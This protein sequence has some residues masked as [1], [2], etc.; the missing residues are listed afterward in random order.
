MLSHVL[1]QFMRNNK[2]YYDTTQKVYT[3]YLV[4]YTFFKFSRILTMMNIVLYNLTCL[5]TW[6]NLEIILKNSLH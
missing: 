4:N 2:M 3:K 6:H 1:K 5:Q